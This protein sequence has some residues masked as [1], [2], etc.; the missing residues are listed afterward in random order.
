MNSTS[1]WPATE[2]RML[3]GIAGNVMLLI[4]GMWGYSGYLGEVG[5]WEKQIQQQDHLIVFST[6][7]SALYFTWVGLVPALLILN[8]HILFKDVLMREI[9]KILLRL[10]SVLAG[11]IFLGILLLVIGTLLINPKWEERFREAGFV[12]CENRVLNFR[13]SVFNDVWVRDSDHCQDRRLRLVLHERFSRDGF[14]LA[15]RYLKALSE[16]PATQ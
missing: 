1:Q 9:P 3:Y 2:N 8:L 12:E 13:K 16:Q 7:T 6:Q 14:E 15:S 4:V 10:Q 5:Y 11:F